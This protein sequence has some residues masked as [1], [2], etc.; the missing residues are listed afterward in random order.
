MKVIISI[1]LMI[2]FILLIMGFYLNDK[3]DQL[4]IR[5]ASIDTLHVKKLYVDTLEP[6]VIDFKNEGYINNNLHIVKQHNKKSFVKIRYDYLKTQTDSEEY[7]Y[8]IMFNDDDGVNQYRGGN[9][10]LDFNEYPNNL[11]SK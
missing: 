8:M 1:M 4:E 2:I 3:V 5:L 6:K 11:Y 7:Y 10:N 9:F